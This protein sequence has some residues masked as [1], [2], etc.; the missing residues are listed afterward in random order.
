MSVPAHPTESSGY[1]SVVRL[2]SLGAAALALEAGWLA[3][4][5]LSGA[6]SHSAL[7]S[8]AFLTDHPLA[9][10]VFALSL[11]I[12]HRF[13]PTLADAPLT[14]P[15][16]DPAFIA[17][18][19]SL[20]G[21]FL[22]LG[23]AYLAG[24]FVLRRGAG[25]ARFALPIL[26]LA[27]L[28]FQVTLLYLPGLF[29]QDVFSYIAYGRLP[30]LYDL[31][32]YVWPPSATP[33]DLIAPWVADVWRT[34]LAPYGPLWL[35]VQ[36][37]M[38]NLFRGL[39]IAE[40]ALAYR[41]LAQSLLLINLGLLWAVLRRRTTL[42]RT[43]RLT[44]LAA[45]AWNPLVLF[46]IGANAHN[47]VL[48][49]T[50]SLLAVLFLGRRGAGALSA[51]GF[52]LGALVKYLSGIA[53]IWLA[54]AAAVRTTSLKDRVLR[55]GLLAL[56]GVTLLVATS[57]PWLELPDS[58]EPL[59]AETAN[60]GYVNSLPDSLGLALADQVLSPVGGFSAELAHAMTRT[61]ERVA[62]LVAFG[63][64]LIWEGR[65]IARRP[66]PESIAAAA[67]RSC[68]IYVLL[69][70]TSVQTWYFC[71]PVAL[72]LARGWEPALSRITVGYSLLALPALYLSYYLRD[73]TPLPVF[74]AYGLVPLVPLIRPSARLA[75]DEHAVT[76]A[77]GEQERVGRAPVASAVMEQ[78]GPLG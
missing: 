54:L 26:V 7:F 71:L 43:G 12:A 67:A 2:V 73:L 36:W 70:S 56:V 78:P 15:L 59:M 1:P 53:I 66:L 45:L 10:H 5:P 57:L 37:A 58:L 61:L 24:L 25:G 34:Y 28:V 3:L 50:L 74:I 48:M 29:S 27:T 52:V 63:A 75:S 33:K 22:W 16:G 6:L 8:S 60:V 23:A 38:A 51:A 49:V 21:V 13:M 9:G 69:V 76:S 4:W 14:Q 42:D 40:Q 46:E 55:L 47:D 35:D 65:R 30:A 77:H 62:M 11:T 64:Y 31:N 19:L 32:P 17:P 20:A 68:L 18:A 39:P 44:A 41:G 72:A